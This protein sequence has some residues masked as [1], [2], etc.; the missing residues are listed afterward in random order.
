VEQ[1][2]VEQETGARILDAALQLFARKG[3]EYV[4]VQEIAEAVGVT[5][6]TLYYY[7]KSK[8]GLLEAIL[9]KHGVEL[10]RVTRSAA[11]YHHDLVTNLT[12]LFRET[13]GFA[14]LDASFYRLWRSLFA[15]APE[16]PGY[17]LG[18]GLRREIVALLEGLFAGASGDHGNMRNREKVYAETF[19]GLLETWAMLSIN[20]E[21]RIDDQL[22]YRIIHQ[23][24]HGIFS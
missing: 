14:H 17:A 10:I 2:T 13:I 1:E 21:T 11:E 20:G 3:Y 24:M 5:K 12:R 18:S 9:A 15:S 6:P 8:Q 16:S 19:L 7:F 4:S 22:Q 23:Y